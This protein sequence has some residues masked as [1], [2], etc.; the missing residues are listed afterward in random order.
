MSRDLW[1]AAYERAIDD[2]IEAHDR[3]PT[4][5]ELKK[6]YDDHSIYEDYVAGIADSR[7]E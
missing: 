4:D 5:E 1:I 6:M 7:P 3:E 2:F